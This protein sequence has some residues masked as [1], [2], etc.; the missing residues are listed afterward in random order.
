ME[1]EVFATKEFSQISLSGPLYVVL[2]ITNKCNLKCLHCFNNSP[3][4]ASLSSCE[5][6]DNEIIKLIEELGEMKVAN[7]CFS[8]GEPFIRKELLFRCLKILGRLNI[9]TSIVTNGTLIDKQTAEMLNVL[10]VKE[11][12]VSLDGSNEETHERLRQVKGSFN[13]ALQGIKNLCHSGITTSISYTLNK[14]NASEVGELI[15]ELSDIPIKAL[16]IRP[17][18]EIGAASFLNNKLTAPNSKQYRDVA[19]TIYKY[20]LKGTKFE[21]GFNDPLS[22]IYYY[23]E[24]KVNT[25][26]EIQSDGEIFPS[27]CIPI[28]VGNVRDKSLRNYWDFELKQL[29]MNKKVEEIAKKIYS[30][31]DLKEVT[32]DIGNGEKSKVTLAY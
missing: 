4:S 7:V 28:S 21:I 24:T 14:W 11:V 23:R 29:W 17:L 19:K 6:D 9:R 32:S 10:G 13:L 26:I 1:E 3:K 20:K 16:N 5:L 8:G 18:L 31:K 15:D 2:N 25:V 12:Q 30:C 27:Y 22:H